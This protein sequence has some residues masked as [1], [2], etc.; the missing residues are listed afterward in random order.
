M[1]TAHLLSTL[2]EQCRRLSRFNADMQQL[3]SLRFDSIYFSKELE[4]RL[5][6]LQQGNLPQRADFGRRR[7][8]F[9]ADMQQLRSL[10]L[11]S[12]YSSKEIFLSVLILVGD[13]HV[14][15]ADMQQFMSLSID[16]V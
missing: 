11:E 15:N 7:S 14:F 5:P 10:R 2:R 13:F 9:N 4:H 1:V 3:R 12:L 6:L 8:R 16:P